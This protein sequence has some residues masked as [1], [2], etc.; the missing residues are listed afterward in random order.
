MFPAPNN[1]SGDWAC[2]ETRGDSRSIS[3]DSCPHVVVLEGHLRGGRLRRSR[4][5]GTES[6][7]GFLLRATA[8]WQGRKMSAWRIGDI[9]DLSGRTA[10]VTGG[11]AGL[12][13]RSALELA[14]KGARVFIAC[15]DAEKGTAAAERIRAEAPGA[16][17]DA[18]A[19]DL[20]EPA[21]IE[22]FA[23]EVSRRSERLDI[24]LNNAGV[25]SLETLER[26]PA[27]HEM[28]MAT[29]HYGHFA[30]T[31]RLFG[32]LA[33]TRGA[34]VVTVTSGGSRY[35][36]I[37]FDDLEWRRRPYR[38]VRAYADSKFANLLFMRALQGRFDAAGAEALSLAAH[39]GLTATQRQQSIGAGGVLFRLLASPVETGVA[40]QLRAATDPAARKRDFYGPR[41]GI[42]GSA[43]RIPVGDKV[44]DDSLAERLWEVT[45]EITD[46]R[47]PAPPV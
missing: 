45:E 16:C 31:G 30:L 7:H 44:A 18:L 13:Y 26:T 14:C 25:V 46:V 4:R 24:L 22:G 1:W 3:T 27:G 20:I 9:P 10:V 47:Y 5:G 35:G 28:H 33:A 43:R 36:T 40:P 38:R 11:N 15:R 12:G 23:D 29:N 34:R 2:R 19:L 32:L 39:P 21:S 6:D 8:N 42:W 41:F 17:I 37:D